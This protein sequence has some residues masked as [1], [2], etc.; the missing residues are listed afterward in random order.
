MKI[1]PKW[2][3]VITF[4]SVT[5]LLAGCPTYQVFY[6]G[7]HGRAELNRATYNRQ[8]K[9]QEANAT[10]DAATSLAEAEVIR[11]QGVAKANLIIGQSLSGNELYLQY[12]WLQTL[13]VNNGNII[14]IPTEAHMPILEAG[15]R[16]FHK[17]SLATGKKHS[18]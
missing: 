1:S 16:N 2:A 9:V 6:A 10:K 4:L 3:I 7:M 5:A 17:D 15:R 14:Y 12:L 18:D 8:I 13:E 11:A